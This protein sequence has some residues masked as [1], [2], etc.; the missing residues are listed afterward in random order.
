MAPSTGSAATDT[1]LH[2][3]NHILEIIA[4][5]RPLQEVLDQ[6]CLHIEQLG[7]GSLCSILLM[8]DHGESLRS[9][10][11]PSLSPEYLDIL[12][13]L[14]VGRCAGS[15]GTA[16]FEGRPVIVS[17]VADDPRWADFRDVAERFQIGACWSAPFFSQSDKVLGTFAISHALPCEPTEFQIELMGAAAN[18]AGI[19]AERHAFDMAALQTE[20][21]ESLGV[22][23]GGLAHDFNNLLTSI[24]GGISLAAS[25]CDKDSAIGQALTSAEI[26]SMRAR[27][28]TQQLLTFARGGAP[29]T[30]AESVQGLLQETAEFTLHGSS[31]TYNLHCAE[32]L[33]Q[34]QI[35]RGQFS[36]AVQNILLNAAQAMPEGGTI[37]IDADV[38]EYRGELALPME[39]GTYVRIQIADT[40]AG[41]AE[42]HLESIFDPY[43]STKEDGRG[44]GLATS[45][46]IL[47][48]HGGCIDAS[49]TPGTGTRLVMYAPVAARPEELVPPEAYDATVP[50]GLRVLIM[51]DE[52]MLL[53]VTSQVLT[54]IGCTWTTVS[55][56]REALDAYTLARASGQ[57]FDATILDLTIPGDRG[58]DHTA[59]DLRRLH[60]EA[61]LIVS[62]GYRDSPV[63]SEY[64][65][66][67]FD[68]VL[69]KPYRMA[70]LH[71]VLAACPAAFG[72][73]ASSG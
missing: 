73:R 23:A 3:Q 61:W 62:S 57:P 40:G 2:T 35:D 60:P 12:D 20:K 15:C 16:A 46:S 29:V 70:D 21:M 69:P 38:L 45:Y 6:L 65:H 43:F 42:H 26:A 25:H 54:R 72:G 10:A 18:L 49:S 67:G 11:G 66:H 71:R 52:E 44:L 28:I 4:R 48:R 7:Q 59:R 53:R 27:D 47:K 41:I 68:A 63:M 13:G 19:A 32:P 8:N 9:A 51:D 34:A 55:N 31:T 14:Q 64:R 24:L 50:L 36:Q 17:N 37:Q 22:L 5:G 39:A 1:L 56:G 58:G 33:P 30:R